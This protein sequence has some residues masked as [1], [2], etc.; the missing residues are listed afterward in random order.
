MKMYLEKNNA[1]TKILVNSRDKWYTFETADDGGR[2]ESVD[3]QEGKLSEIAAELK[4]KVNLENYDFENWDEIPEYKNKSI[5]EISDMENAGRSCDLVEY[6]FVVGQGEIGQIIT[7]DNIA[8][9]YDSMQQFHDDI[10]KLLCEESRI[11]IKPYSEGAKAEAAKAIK[12]ANEVLANDFFAEARSCAKDDVPVYLESTNFAGKNEQ[13]PQWK[14]SHVR[15]EDCIAAIKNAIKK[16]TQYLDYGKT[17]DINNA[18]A[19]VL[20]DFS[21]ERVSFITAST[22]YDSLHDGRYDSKVKEWAKKQYE[23]L[24]DEMKADANRNRLHDNDGTCHPIV[25]NGFTKSVIA[26]QDI[27]EKMKSTIE[28]TQE[29]YKN[30]TEYDDSIA[31]SLEWIDSDSA[32][33]LIADINDY[34][35]CF[36]KI[37]S[38]EMSLAASATE[39]LR[40]LLNNYKVLVSDE[41]SRKELSL[42]GKI[43]I[44]DDSYSKVIETNTYNYSDSFKEDLTEAIKEYGAG[45]VTCL[46][47]TAE[48]VSREVKQS[49]SEKSTASRKSN[50]VK[51]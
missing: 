33:N 39:A 40:E 41:E 15:N 14:E 27:E 19:K 6:E 50:N 3:I 16:N 20:N 28:K 5:S 34:L 23:P 43:E 47:Y 12:E 24:S 45:R 46:D 1:E 29:F 22:I 9:K 48:C 2:F 38:H 7:A 25:F 30:S 26:M 17:V 42:K 32:L 21:L 51:R 11:K 8:H 35:Y 10:C 4:T 18:L 31:K 37:S 13:F 36:D 49:L 44:L